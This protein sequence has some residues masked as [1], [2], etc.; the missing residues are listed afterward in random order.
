[1]HALQTPALAG[2]RFC[3][4]VCEVHYRPRYTRSAEDILLARAA[5]FPAT[6]ADLYDPDDMRDVVVPME[7]SVVGSLSNV[8]AV[9]N[10]A[11]WPTALREVRK[12]VPDAWDSMPTQPMVEPVT[13]MAILNAAE[14]EIAAS[15]DETAPDG[16]GW[17][18]LN[19]WARLAEGD[20]TGTPSQI[21]GSKSQSLAPC[22]LLYRV[23]G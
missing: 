4:A 13:T 11:G 1:M 7:W 10:G 20:V 21:S 15:C 9:Q 3:V 19:E 8:L 23:N 16:T 12:P 6:L 17:F 22:P 5:H 18:G 14:Q 2:Q